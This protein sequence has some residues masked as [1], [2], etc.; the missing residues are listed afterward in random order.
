MESAS[1]TRNA[2]PS[3]VTSARWASS[4]PLANLAKP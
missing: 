2:S 1:D 4:I 3:S